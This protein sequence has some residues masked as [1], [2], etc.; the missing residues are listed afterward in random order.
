MSAIAQKTSRQIKNGEIYG[1]GVISIGDRSKTIKRKNGIA[2]SQK[3]EA[4]KVT[5]RYG[6]VKGG[7]IV[8][9]KK[10]RKIDQLAYSDNTKKIDFNSEASHYY[11]TRHGKRVLVRKGRNS[12]KQIKDDILTGV[13]YGGASL[14][15]AVGTGTGAMLVKKVG[16]NGAIRNSAMIAG[17]TIGGAL[18]AGITND[19]IDHHERRK[20]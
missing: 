17:A 5:G 11:Q 20:K 8:G 18:A 10:G 6:S 1:K 15:L 16:Q 14:G 13:R 12:R 7:V 2:I 3:G 9:R 4:V 19:I